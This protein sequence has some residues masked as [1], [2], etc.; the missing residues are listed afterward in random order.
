MNRGGIGLLVTL[1][2]RAQRSGDA[3]ARDRPVRPLPPDPR[4]DPPRRGDRDPRRRGRGHRGR[5]RLTAMTTTEPTSD[6]QPTTA[7][8]ERR[9][10]RPTATPATGPSR[11]IGCR[12]PASPAPR[13]I[14][15]AASA[16]PA[17]CRAS[18][19]C[20]RRRSGSGST[21]ST[22][23][24]GGRRHLE[25]ALPDVLAEGRSGSTRRS[26]GSRPGEVALLDIAPRA[27][28]A[29][30][31][32]DRGHG[33]LRRRRVVHV[34][35]PR[36]PYAVGV[37]HLLRLSRRRRDRRPGAGPRAD[38]P[39]RSTSSPTCSAATG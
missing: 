1:L 21:A 20:G 38:R 2:V 39:T 5:G 16:C 13:S 27:R 3:A 18:A 7:P 4:A 15:S 35:D 26:P 22:D 30:Q 9:A 29:G 11:S 10:R 25:G 33:H 8:T 17:R 23:A 28:G 32:L 36:R 19:S 14:P 31:A 34:H 24:A 6:R 12:R 37:D